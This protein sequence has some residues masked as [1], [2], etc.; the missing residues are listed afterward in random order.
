MREPRVTPGLAA[1]AGLPVVP[2]AP[3]RWRLVVPV[4][5]LSLAKSRLAP[6]TGEHR[7]ELAL[8]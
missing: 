2:P 8:A 4:K 1:R 3:R 6:A 5:P 7:G